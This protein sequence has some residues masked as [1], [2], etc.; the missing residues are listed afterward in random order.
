MALGIVWRDRI[1]SIHQSSK[2][3]AAEYNCC[4][5]GCTNNHNCSGAAFLLGVF[6]CPVPPNDPKGL[7]WFRPTFPLILVMANKM[8][9]HAFEVRSFLGDQLLF[10]RGLTG[11]SC[12][13][14]GRTGVRLLYRRA[15]AH[16]WQEQVSDTQL[17]SVCR[18]GHINS[19]KVELKFQLECKLCFPCAQ[20]ILRQ[21]QWTNL[22]VS[23]EA[24]YWVSWPSLE[25][26][27][28]VTAGSKLR[29]T[30]ARK[31][32]PRLVFTLL[33]NVLNCPVP[34]ETQW[35]PNSRACRFRA[36]QGCQSVSTFTLFVLE[37]TLWPHACVWC[38]VVYSVPSTILVEPGCTASV[39]ASGDVRIE[40][41]QTGSSHP[42]IQVP[43]SPIR[44]IRD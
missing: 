43:Q 21:M 13:R 23:I 2:S 26:Q 32:P 1:Q 41:Q 18:H 22:S 39:T 19:L 8:C 11:H 5:P 24:K 27:R 9:G 20:S 3:T 33:P 38:D 30:Y 31:F 34:W 28:A 16:H 36:S 37:V 12:V 35:I 25:V 4:V 40:V 42:C 14:A 7:C 17:V 6:A 44:L 10:W 15:R 29:W